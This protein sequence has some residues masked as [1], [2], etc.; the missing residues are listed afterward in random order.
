MSETEG[1]PWKYVN[2]E[3]LQEI[4]MVKIKQGYTFPLNP[5]WVLC[6]PGWKA[7]Y[8]ALLASQASNVQDSLNCWYPP[9]S[10]IREKIEEISKKYPSGFVRSPVDAEK[11]NTSQFNDEEDIDGTAAMDLAEQELRSYETLRR[12]KR[13]LRAV[14]I[15]MSFIMDRQNEVAERKKEKGIE[16]QKDEAG[17]SDGEALRKNLQPLLRQ[18]I[19]STIKHQELKIRD[20]QDRADYV[21]KL[22]DRLKKQKSFISR[23]ASKTIPLQ[24]LKPKSSLPA[25]VVSASIQGR[26]AGKAFRS[27]LTPLESSFAEL[28]LSDSARASQKKSGRLESMSSGTLGFLDESGC[29]LDASSSR[30]GDGPSALDMPSQLSNGRSSSSEEDDEEKLEGTDKSPQ[31]ETSKSTRRER[32]SLGKSK[33]VSLSDL[34]RASNKTT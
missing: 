2:V 22:L 17:L 1:L 24:Q 11:L 6:D 19:I 31:Q 21:P 14:L 30:L 16:S 34:Q 5:K 9:E 12:A 13:K 7:V 18:R 26:Y 4:L 20:S 32:G 33:Q 29:S 23:R 15:W 27:S 28:D 8:D 3:G 10:G 25:G